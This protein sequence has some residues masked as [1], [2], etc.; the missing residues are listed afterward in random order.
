M[1]DLL[2]GNVHRLL[3]DIGDAVLTE[4]T[5]NLA[6]NGQWVTG[7]LA[8]SG[9]MEVN[10][11]ELEVTVIFNAP[12]AASVEYGSRPHAAPLGPSLEVDITESPIRRSQQI[13]IKRKIETG[14]RVEGVRGL[15]KGFP[16]EVKFSGTPDPKANPFDYW[17]WRRGKRKIINTKYGYHTALGYGVWLKILTKGGDPHP[18]LRPAIDKVKA[19]LGFY[20]K[21]YGLDV[22]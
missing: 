1:A 10:K 8:K 7:H 17:A 11:A 5:E 22:E 3:N 20:A 12:Y 13:K 19:F 14:K 16:K 15:A 21:K 2:L 18:Y 9:E 4:A 6:R